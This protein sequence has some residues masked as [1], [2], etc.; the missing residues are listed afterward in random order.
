MNNSTACFLCVLQRAHQLYKQIL[1][2]R[3][4]NSP[5]AVLFIVSPQLNKYCQIDKNFC[6]YNNISPEYHS[7]YKDT[8]ADTFVDADILSLYRSTGQ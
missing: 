7:K 3:C 8:E 6:I 5:T 4:W 2:W 1:G